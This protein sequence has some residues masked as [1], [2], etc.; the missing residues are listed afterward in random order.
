MIID[1]ENGLIEAKSFHEIYVKEAAGIKP[2]TARIVT[3]MEAGMLRA[4]EV[5]VTDEDQAVTIVISDVETGESVR[6]QVTDI[7]LDG[8]VLGHFIAVI[9]WRHMSLEASDGA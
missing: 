3:D 4:L 9:S 6:R 8:A 5:A 2:N 7:T 1:V